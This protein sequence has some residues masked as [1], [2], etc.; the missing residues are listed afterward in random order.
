MGGR[1]CASG[2]G[3]AP[4]PGVEWRGERGE[5][6]GCPFCDRTGDRFKDDWNRPDALCWRCGSHE[7]HRGQWLLLQQRPELLASTSAFLHFAP[8]YC[9]RGPL[10]AAAREHGFRYVTGDLDPAGVD[11]RLDLSGLEL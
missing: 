5:A 3:G 4:P 6:V 8:E 11:L 9:L 2:A 1:P 7:R 10:Q